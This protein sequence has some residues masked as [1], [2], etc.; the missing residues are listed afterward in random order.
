M[1]S[2][3]SKYGAIFLLAGL[4]AACSH[5]SNVASRPT[6][7]V[8]DDLGR[9]VTVPLKITRVVSTA[10][11]ITENVFAAGAGDRLVGVT[12]FCDYP[13]EARAIEKIGD[14]QTPNIERIVSLTPDVVLVSTASQI[15]NFSKTLSA[16][17]ISVYV[18]DPTTLDGVFRG[19]ER[20][21]E[22]F[23]TEEQVARSLPDLKRR[24]AAVQQT[25]RGRR[26]VRVFV[27]IS[28]EP[29][30][31]IGHDS[32]VNNVIVQ[33]GG[34]SVTAAVD[35]AYPKFSKETA[36]SLE[37]EV[38]ILS[39]SDDNQEPNDVFRRSPAVR[40]GRVYRVNADLLARP[41]PRLVDALEQITRMLHPEGSGIIEN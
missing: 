36:A 35:P 22:L 13:D 20:L 7:Q 21:G 37:P 26:K 3:E 2:A 15:E 8:T 6:R 19:L 1:R 41:G 17:G 24:V 16:N 11:S 10:P 38:I 5:S 28:R 32:F 27:Q 25:V 14:T 34:E 30:F 23:G 12:T 4:I 9:T 29:L 33:A 40:N 39:E 18:S 31:T